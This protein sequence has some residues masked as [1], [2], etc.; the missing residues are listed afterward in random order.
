M[1][2]HRVKEYWEAAPCDHRLGAREETLA[3]FCREERRRNTVEPFAPVFADYARWQGKR[4]LEM[5]VGIGTDF[6]RWVRAGAQATGIDLTVSGARLTRRNLDLRGIPR[7]AYHLAVADAEGSCFRS[8]SFDLVYA[9]GVFHHSPRTDLALAE[10]A[11]VLAPGGRLKMMVY[12][13]PSWTG[14]ILWALHGLLRGRPLKS[15]K[16]ILFDHLESPGT[17]AYTVSEI[18]HLVAAGGFENIRTEVHVGPSDLLVIERRPEYR[19]WWLDL[20]VRLWPRPLIR[21][22]G[23]RLGLILCV[24]ARKAAKV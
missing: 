16:P 2:K 13:V 14:W 20:P 4:V 17:K 21:H 11:R 12:H 3:Y 5:G 8:G 7:S 15:V 18:R 9:Y 24:E 22:F 10:A 6:Q 23:Q 1:L 19:R